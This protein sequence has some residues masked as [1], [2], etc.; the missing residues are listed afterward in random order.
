MFTKSIKS[1]KTIKGMIFSLYLLIIKDKTILFRI[2]YQTTGNLF[3]IQIINL[4]E[5][6]HFVKS[7]YKLRRKIRNVYLFK[8]K[9]IY[10]SY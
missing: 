3:V 6:I 2:R 5:S 7:E 8:K 10:R 4:D 9:P 1:A